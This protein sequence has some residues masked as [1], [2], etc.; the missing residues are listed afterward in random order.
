[1]IDFEL[2]LSLLPKTTSSGPLLSKLKLV[3]CN[4]KRVVES[5]GEGEEREGRGRGEEGRGEFLQ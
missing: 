3:I 4:I 5:R 2:F 1:M